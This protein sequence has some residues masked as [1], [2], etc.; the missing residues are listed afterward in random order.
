MIFKVKNSKQRKGKLLVM[1]I[2]FA[3]IISYDAYYF[4]RDR[5]D[6]CFCFFQ[7]EKGSPENV[8]RNT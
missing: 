1:A 3:K 4:Y 5:R 6:D 2:I 8:I 7:N